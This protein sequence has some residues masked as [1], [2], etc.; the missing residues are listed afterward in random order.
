MTTQTIAA[1]Q[2]AVY[3]KVS[4][5]SGITTL[6]ASSAAI[7]DHVP[8]SAAFPYI[9]IADIAAAPMETQQFSGATVSLALETYSRAAGKAE[10]QSIAAA[11]D[12]ALHQADFDVTGHHLVSCRVTSTQIAQVFDA[13]TWRCRQTVEIIVEPIDA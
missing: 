12:A 8:A 3:T 4:C 10:A 13:T 5:D 1:V 7:Y 9:V 2:A 6:L 11:I